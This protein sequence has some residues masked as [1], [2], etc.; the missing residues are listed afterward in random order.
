MP[1]DIPVVAAVA[2]VRPELLKA[3][4]DALFAEVSARLSR[5]RIKRHGASFEGYGTQLAET[6]RAHEKEMTWGD[7]A[8]IL[9]TIAALDDA[10][11]RKHLFDMADRDLS[12]R[13]TEYGG[14]LQLDASGRFELIEYQPQ[15]RGSDV[16]FEASGKMFEDGYD[17]I[18][19]FHFHA[20][21]YDNRRYA[22][23]HLGDFSYADAT[24]VNGLMF[25]Y[26][27]SNT[28]NADFYRHGQVVI[29]LGEVL[30]DG[31]K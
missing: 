25:C 2:V 26:I 31:G 20:Q 30:R 15:S 6:T 9:I 23:P 18:A 5:D 10:A 14:L 3:D 19:H 11:V 1:R 24:G 28:M 29:D 17:A 7:C 8:A 16:R 4:R 22:G 27:D 21:A 13:T 12:D